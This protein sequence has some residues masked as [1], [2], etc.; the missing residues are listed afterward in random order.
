MSEKE[1]LS[2]DQILLTADYNKK[3]AKNGNVKLYI[4]VY[5][6]QDEA[7]FSILVNRIG[8][9]S[10]ILLTNGHIQQGKVSKDEIKYYYFKATSNKPHYAV[11]IP[12]RGNPDLY[13]SII[14]DKEKS[15][16]HWPRYPENKE[17]FS[18][19]LE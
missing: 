10:P 19:F 5:T 3:Y 18:L 13:M 4:G 2:Q 11:V 1:G 12:K 15:M 17:D 16:A 14:T 6:D 9:F 7:S 8:T